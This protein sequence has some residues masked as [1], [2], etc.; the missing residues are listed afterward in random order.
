MQGGPKQDEFL[1]FLVENETDKIC[2]KI[3][4]SE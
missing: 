2:K 4:Y 1:F 3:K